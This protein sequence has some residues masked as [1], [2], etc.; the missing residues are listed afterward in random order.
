MKHIYIC[1]IVILLMFSCRKNDDNLATRNTNRA[2]LVYIGANNNL[3]SEA[4]SSINQMEE[5]VIGLKADVYVYANLAGT[6]PKI[7]KIFP[8]RSPEIKSKVLKS[9]GD[10][11]SSD[12]LVMKE[13]LQTMCYY[14]GDRTKALILW[15]HAT[16]WIPDTEIKLKSFNVDN[17]RMMDLKDLEE[18]IPTGLDFLMFDACSMAS[19]EVLYQLR[20]KALYTIAS[21]AEVLSTSMPYNLLL[22]YLVDPNLKSGL[23]AAAKSYVDYY[24]AQPGLRRSATISV[25]NNQYWS[26]LGDSFRNALGN[27]PPKS[28]KRDKLQRLDFDPDSPTAGFDFLDFIKQYLDPSYLTTIEYALSQLVVY[29]AHTPEFLGK[30]IEIFSGLSIYVPDGANKWVHPYYNSLKWSIDSGY[31]KFVIGYEKNENL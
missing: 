28:I 14:I 3:V 2:I 5:G 6:S 21:P 8:D 10:H 7:Y 29:K 27:S 1:Y 23:K 17:G 25:I 15:S 11:D 24:N 13:I 20:A 19:V 31:N 12:P 16:N 26:L 30:P 9:Y 18:V 22:K 4:Y